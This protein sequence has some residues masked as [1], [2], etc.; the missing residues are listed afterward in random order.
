M[1]AAGLGGYSYWEAGELEPQLLDVPLQGL[2]SGFNGCRIAVLADLHHGWFISRDYIA[3]AVRLA[4]SLGL[5]L[6]AREDGDGA[7][8]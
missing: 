5:F 4:N 6:V 8:V 3:G 7:R 2:P 1:A